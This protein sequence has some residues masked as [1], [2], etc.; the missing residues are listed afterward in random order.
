MAMAFIKMKVMPE[1]PQSDLKAIEDECRQNFEVIGAKVHIVDI[2]PIAFG[3]N[4]IIFTISWPE[5]KDQ[6]MVEDAIR[7]VGNIQ[8]AEIIDFRRA[9]G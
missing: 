3:L 9:F 2:E 1:S 5:E 7:K 4:A 8:S 6:S